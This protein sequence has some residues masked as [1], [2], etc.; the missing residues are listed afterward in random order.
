MTK[1]SLSL[2][3]STDPAALAQIL[4]DLAQSIQAGTICLQKGAEHVTLKPVQRMDF[5]LEATVK[6]SKQKLT[7]AIKWEEQM[8]EEPQECFKISAV[9]PEP[10][11]PEVSETPC[12][13]DSLEPP[14]AVVEPGPVLAEDAPQPQEAPKDKPVK[15]GKKK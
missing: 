13:C 2:N 7:I 11:A 8:P 10:A 4:I 5:E 9:A 6:K 15:P 3:G 14:L 12:G 1:S